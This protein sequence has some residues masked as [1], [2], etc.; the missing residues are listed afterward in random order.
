MLKNNKVKILIIED[1]PFLSEM[2]LAKLIQSGFDVDVASDGKTGL[3]KVKTLMPTLVLLDIVLPQ[4]DGF[5]ILED[6]RKNQKLKDILVVLLTNLG[7]RG[8]VERGVALGANG[9][10]IKAH[11]TPTAVVAKVKEVLKVNKRQ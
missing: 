3:D 1:D 5:E 2:Y 9:Y 6:I 10:I 8:D 7:Q 11:Y 4:M